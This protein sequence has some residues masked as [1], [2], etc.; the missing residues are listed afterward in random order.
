MASPIE[1]KVGDRVATP[2]GVGSTSFHT[3]VRI[4]RTG[5]FVTAMGVLGTVWMDVKS[6]YPVAEYER[7]NV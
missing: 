5:I 1:Y 6:V 7:R 2:C 4:G 3:V